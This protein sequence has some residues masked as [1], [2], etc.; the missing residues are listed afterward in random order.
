MTSF[1]GTFVAGLQR[2]RGGCA[3][4]RVS[5]Q[6]Y[7]TLNPLLPPLISVDNYDNYREH[8]NV[9]DSGDGATRRY[10]LEVYMID[11]EQQREHATDRTLDV[12]LCE[13]LRQML[14]SVNPYVSRFVTFATSDNAIGN[15]QVIVLPAVAATTS[16]APVEPITIEQQRLH[17]RGEDTREMAAL[18]HAETAYMDRRN[19][20]VQLR[21]DESHDTRVERRRRM[22]ELHRSSD[23]LQYPL[24]FPFGDDAYTT[25]ID[26]AAAAT[27]AGTATGSNNTTVAAAD[28]GRRIAFSPSYTGSP[29][30]L[31]HCIQSVFTYVREYGN[32]H[33]F[34][35]MTCN[36]YWTEVTNALLSGQQVYDRYDL[37]CRVFRLKL[38]RL[39]NAVCGKHGVFGET[40][41]YSYN[42]EIQKCGL[43]H[44]HMV[45]WLKPG[46]RSKP[47][48]HCRK[49]PAGGGGDCQQ[50]YTLDNRWV[51]LYCPLL[52]R[53]LNT[54]VNVEA[55]D[56][57]YVLIYLTKMID[58]SAIGERYAPTAT[59]TN[60]DDD[61]SHDY[62]HGRYFSTAEAV[63]RIFAFRTYGNW[64]PVITLDVHLPDE[65]RILLPDDERQPLV[66]V[67][68]PQPP[69]IT[70]IAFC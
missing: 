36:P 22:S 55:I 64:P 18:M 34:I 54:H 15:D 11:L 19:G 4:F 63:W 44:V 10:P 37:L 21:E 1:G 65:E 51:I 31:H 27:S 62:V 56:L 23:A 66:S 69:A 58:S 49:L 12:T 29:Q 50:E 68:P 16:F 17:D 3:T 40:R 8:P 30:N 26:A 9:A 70:L 60:V 52:S 2:G 46:P 25:A 28:V 67:L 57:L 47:T 48:R 20:I 14:R 39:V 6:T 59:M 41:C 45:V 7:H 42:V 43:P 32:P 5:G 53:A 24:M 61:A 13:Q 38:D 33:V 35:T